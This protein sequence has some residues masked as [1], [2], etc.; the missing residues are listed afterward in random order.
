MKNH[1][2]KSVGLSIYDNY[3][4]LGELHESGK[5]SD[6]EWEKAECWFEEKRKSAVTEYNACK[7]PWPYQWKNIDA[8]VCGILQQMGV[9]SI[10]YSDLKDLY[11]AVCVYEA[12]TKGKGANNE[13]QLQSIID[14]IRSE[15]LTQLRSSKKV[16]VTLCGPSNP[17]NLLVKLADC[18]DG[19]NVI[20]Q[21]RKL[22]TEAIEMELSLIYVNKNQTYS[23]YGYSK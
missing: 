23:K 4:A 9:V 8:V 14:T 19:L 1:I 22:S 10:D 15:Y 13:E 2:S 12:R 20:G 16:V 7:G 18:M 6:E 17:S 11:D 3:A 5:L 21:T